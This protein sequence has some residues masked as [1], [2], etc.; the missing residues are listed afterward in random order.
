MSIAEDP[1]RIKDLFLVDEKNSVGVYAA[2][3][4]QL[5]MPVTVIVDDYLPLT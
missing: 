1:E 4:Y 2:T 5:G 3:M